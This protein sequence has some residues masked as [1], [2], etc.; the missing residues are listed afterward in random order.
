MALERAM[1]VGRKYC[2]SSSH[3]NS[4]FSPMFSRDLSKICGGAVRGKIHC[5][6][7]SIARRN[8]GVPRGA[9]PIGKGRKRRVSLLEKAAKRERNLSLN[10]SKNLPNAKKKKKNIYNAT[11]FSYIS[12]QIFFFILI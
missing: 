9:A 2:K 8:P 7:T 5:Q 12:V 1:K 10:I 3:L 6:P 4:A 11:E